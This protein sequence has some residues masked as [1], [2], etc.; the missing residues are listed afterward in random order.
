[1]KALPWEGEVEHH[2]GN[3]AILDCG[4]DSDCN[5]LWPGEAGQRCQPA[6]HRVAG[7]PQ[8]PPGRQVSPTAP[9]SQQPI[10]F[11]LFFGSGSS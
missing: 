3:A 9:L 1:M 10:S 8:Q 2:H 7:Q 4:L 11:S 5:D 6:P